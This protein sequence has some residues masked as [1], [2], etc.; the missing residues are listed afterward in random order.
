MMV[1]IRSV[2]KASTLHAGLRISVEDL[3]IPDLSEA[4]ADMG[5]EWAWQGCVGFWRARVAFSG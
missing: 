1:V 4:Y 3:P 5:Y 2:T